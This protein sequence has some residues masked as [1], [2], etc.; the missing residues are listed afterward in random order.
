L[1]FEGTVHFTGNGSLL[2]LYEEDIW[3]LKLKLK[4]S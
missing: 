1:D 4:V 2:P 3:T